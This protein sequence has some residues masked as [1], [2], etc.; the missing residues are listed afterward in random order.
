MDDCS[1]H[2]SAQVWQKIFNEY[3]LVSLFKRFGHAIVKIGD[4][5]VAVG[6]SKLHPD[7]ILDTIEKFDEVSGWEEIS[8]KMKHPRANFGYTL[9]PH[10]FFGGCKLA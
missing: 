9:V 6:G 4:L 8:V 5:V 2:E 10:S 7:V 1:A 3:S